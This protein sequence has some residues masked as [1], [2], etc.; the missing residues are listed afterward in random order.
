VTFAKV[1]ETITL[2]V[3]DDGKGLPEAGET[4]DGGL[5]SMIIRQ[6]A[7]QFGGQPEYSERA[8]GGTVVTVALPSLV[9]DDDDGTA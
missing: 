1:G 6:L 2:T 7:Q 5:G 8:G 4:S 3:E 9:P